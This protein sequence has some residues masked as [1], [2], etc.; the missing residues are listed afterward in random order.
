MGA[1]GVGIFE[2]DV[3]CDVRNLFYDLLREGLPLKE[4]TDALMEEMQE[5][6]EDE[7]D[8]P[9]IILALAATEWEAGR[10]DARIK[11]RALKLIE[12]GVDFRWQD[13]DSKDD[14]FQVLQALKAKLQSAPPAP[15]DLEEL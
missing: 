1:W 14:R 15:R 8:G 3:A 4:A 9:V 10:L 2:D 5:E 13:T 11:R 12:A 6:L 7:E